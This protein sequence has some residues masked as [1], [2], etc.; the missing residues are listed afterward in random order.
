MKHNEMKNVQV[1]QQKNVNQKRKTAEHRLSDQDYLTCK[2]KHCP[3]SY[4]INFS[5]TFQNLYSHLRAIT[6][7][8]NLTIKS[9]S[10]KCDLLSFSKLN[11]QII[12]R[13][14]FFKNNQFFLHVK[15]GIEIHVLNN[16]N[17]EKMKTKSF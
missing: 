14:I 4:H 3:S 16:L 7:N 8:L 12:L 10:A 6:L 5:C 11:K 9:T 15:T 1:Q 2:V 17:P 13:E